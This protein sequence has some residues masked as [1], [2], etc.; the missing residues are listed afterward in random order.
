MKEKANAPYISETTLT[1][2]TLLD[3]LGKTAVLTLGVDL[4]AA[5]GDA[6]RIEKERVN[7]NLVSLSGTDPFCEERTDFKFYP[8]DANK[9]IFD[10]WQERTVDGQNL[11][12][13]LQTW[14][15][16]VDGLVR[17]PRIFTFSELLQLKR[18]DQ[19]TDFHCVEGW[20]VYDIPWNG[21]HMSTL[22]DIVEPEPAATYVTFHTTNDIYNESLPVDVALEEKT[23]LAYGVD[24]AT[25]P[26]RH[27]FPLRLVV[28][29][30]MAYKS[31]KYVYRIELDN[32]PVL[33]AWVQWGYP[34]DA[35][36]PAGRLRPGKY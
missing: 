35:P 5:C 34:Y 19:I 6:G 22:F 10:L 16:Q 1:R 20:S 27:G 9:E 29:R 30:M 31:A 36:V 12:E 23:M 2:R 24:C 33:G 15:L 17:N 18:H 26:L 3:W 25:I 11:L 4:L 21:I 7:Q 32:K 13:T 8:G 28:P 14:K